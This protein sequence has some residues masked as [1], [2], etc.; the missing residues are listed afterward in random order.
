MAAAGGGLIGLALRNALR[1]EAA[2]KRLEARVR[3]A[4]LLR[5]RQ[6]RPDRDVCVI[7]TVEGE[8]TA[9]APLSGHICVAWHVTLEVR[10]HGG[11]D[12]PHS[13]WHF[14]LLEKSDAPLEISDDSGRATV[15]LAGADWE[16]ATAYR[17]ELA[18]KSQLAA[19]VR[20]FLERHRFDWKDYD[21]TRV[22]LCER[23]LVRGRPVVVF[24]Q[25]RLDGAAALA[26]GPGGSYRDAPARLVFAARPDACPLVLLD[27]PAAAA[28]K[29]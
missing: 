5:L 28:G 4:P 13:P 14:E 10:S 24:G 9:I 3:A 27:P 1:A 12:P 2:R 22:R 23:L 19:H 15:D 8:R 26:G 7:A 20:Q 11:T 29:R 17:F 6:V 16:L 21:E 25:A 18:R